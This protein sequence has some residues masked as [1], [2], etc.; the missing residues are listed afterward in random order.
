MPVP[1]TEAFSRRNASVMRSAAERTGGVYIDGGSDSASS[2][3]LSYLA[4]FTAAAGFGSGGSEPKQ[5]HAF[6]I[7]LALCAYAVSKFLPLLP[8]RKTFGK[9]LILIAA[10][11]FTSCSEGRLLLLEAN[12]LFSRERYEEA[13]VP[14]Q[15]ALEYEDSA[16]YAEYGLGLTLY[17]LDEENSALGRFINSKKILDT[18][19]VNEHRELRYRNFYNS[20][21]IYFEEENYA[22]AAEAFKE[23]LRINP[24]RIDAKRNLEITIMSINME[25]KQETPADGGRNETREILFDYIKQQEQQRWK[26]GEWLQEEQFME[27]DY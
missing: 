3:L 21:I 7:I 10:L 25:P 2:D 9:S 15:K 11:I 16:P 20:G 27:F 1:G 18:L 14:Y 13:V 8:A 6:F 22:S 26:S 12:Y 5:R 4:S 23:A 17:L 24:G 19:S